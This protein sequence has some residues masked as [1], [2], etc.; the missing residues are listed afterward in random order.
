M[1]FT[2][3]FLKFLLFVSALHFLT[4]SSVV[5]SAQPQDSSACPDGTTATE[6]GECANIGVADVVKEDTAT[7]PT[8]ED[9]KCPSR[10]HIIRCAAKHLDTNKNN[11]LD[12]VELETAIDNLPW[13]ARGVLKI[14]GS[15]NSI[16]KKCDYDGDDAISIDFD[17]DNTVDTCLA[18]CFKRRAFKNAF[19][20]DCDL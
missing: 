1:E 8:P 16:M 7:P 14:I 6:N 10:P 15:V 17:M 4:V 3:R 2:R 5:T 20:A 19:F 11:K 18:T 12:R 9:P 13:L